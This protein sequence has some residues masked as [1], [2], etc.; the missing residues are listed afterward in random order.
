[1]RGVSKSRQRRLVLG[2][3]PTSEHPDAS[4]PFFQRFPIVGRR[5]DFECF[6]EAAAL[7]GKPVM[8]DP[9]YLQVLTLREGMNN[10]GKRRHSMERILRDYTPNTPLSG[11]EMR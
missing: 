2:G 8:T 7:L 6:R 4:C 1:M 3:Q 5:H 10:G 11:G 9:D